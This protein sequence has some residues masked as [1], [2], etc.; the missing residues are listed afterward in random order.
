M[1]ETH[2]HLECGET[3]GALRDVHG[4]SAEVLKNFDCAL[5]VFGGE[6]GND[7]V[8]HD[9]DAVVEAVHREVEVVHDCFLSSLECAEAEPTDEPTLSQEPSGVNPILSSDLPFR[10]I[11]WIEA[12]NPF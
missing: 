6:H 11:L 10:R 9:D 4:A 3:I 8:R 1:F 12:R 2:I 5:S 7:L